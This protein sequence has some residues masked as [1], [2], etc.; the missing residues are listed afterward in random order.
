MVARALTSLAASY[1][2]ERWSSPVTA[3]EFTGYLARI[4]VVVLLC[5]SARVLTVGVSRLIRFARARSETRNFVPELYR[6]LSANSLNEAIVF[7]NS[8]PRSHVAPVLADGLVAYRDWPSDQ[9]SKEAAESAERAMARAAARLMANLRVGLNSLSN[10]AETAFSLGFAASIF[11]ISYAVT[12]NY[13]DGS[14]VIGPM[15]VMLFAAVLPLTIGLGLSAIAVCANNYF[16][17]RV[18]TLETESKDA[19][20][21][22]TSYLVLHLDLAETRVPVRSPENVS[23]TSWEVAYD[24]QRLFVIPM[25]FAVFLI[26]IVLLTGSG[27]ALANLAVG[28]MMHVATTPHGLPA[29]P[30]ASPQLGWYWTP[31]WWWRRI[32]V[33]TRVLILMLPVLFS[34]AMWSSTSLMMRLVRSRRR[35]EGLWEKTVKA[36]DAGKFEDAICVSAKSET[37]LVARV[38]ET[39]LRAYQLWRSEMTG[40]EAADACERATERRISELLAELRIGTNSLSNIASTAAFFGFS[41]TTVGIIETFG[42][43][44]SKWDVLAGNA[45]AIS[46]SLVPSATGIAIA[47]FALWLRECFH[48]IL[49]RRA[50][51]LRLA[52]SSL[53]SYLRCHPKVSTS[54]G[55]PSKPMSEGDAEVCHESQALVLAPVLLGTAVVAVCSVVEVVRG[56]LEWLSHIHR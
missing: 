2:W 42:G 47:I 46:Y 36:L 13:G 11:G 27:V 53:V 49:E 25:M 4:P 22:L 7:A 10:I 34:Q 14:T 29:V 12:V 32:S 9:S 26:C 28:Q 23:H 3:W 48:I 21:E 31:M 38:L 55:T 17:S 41:A 35:G 45:A 51:E 6:L 20:S 52:A 54:S 39:G 44:G 43:S 33:I 15:S 1:P 40:R 24:P 18:A 50:L 8:R 56:V 37:D 16:V 5:M 30:N 19:S